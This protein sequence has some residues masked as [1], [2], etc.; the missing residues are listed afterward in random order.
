MSSSNSS[1]EAPPND[2]KPQYFVAWLL[3]ALFYLYQYAARSAPGVMQ[4]ELT[5]AWGG[6]Q[7]GSIISAYYVA[8]AVSALAAGVLLDRYGA[9]RVVPY[10]VACVGAGCAIFAQG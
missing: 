8:Y 10:A 5:A 9:S 1:N 4:D 6:N 3:C 2:L 7:I